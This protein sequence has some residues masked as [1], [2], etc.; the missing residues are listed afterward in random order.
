MRSL[1]YL[2]RFPVVAQPAQVC[3]LKW[4]SVS[5][6]AIHTKLTTRDFF[7]RW[8]A[9]E[10]LW[11]WHIRLRPSFTIHRDFAYFDDDGFYYITGRKKRFVK[12]FGNRINLNDIDKIIYDNFENIEFATYGIDDQIYIFIEDENIGKAIKAA[13]AQKTKINPVAFKIM[14][15]ESLPRNAS[16]KISYSDL[17]KI[18][19]KNKHFR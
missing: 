2:Q 16:G 11:T 18:I 15:I 7:F 3:I 4:C 8:R 9:R 17:S 1:R 6:S 19:E 13:I 12:V 14:S 5:A 10:F